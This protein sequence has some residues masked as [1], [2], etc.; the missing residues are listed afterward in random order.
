LQG[1]P[2]K[3]SGNSNIKGAWKRPPRR[4]SILEKTVVTE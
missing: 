4:N 1:K 2:S 3:L